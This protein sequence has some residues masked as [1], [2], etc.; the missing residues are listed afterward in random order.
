MIA[1]TQQPLGPV[2]TQPPAAT[3]PVLNELERSA[4]LRAINSGYRIAPERDG[5]RHPLQTLQFFGIRP[6]D[7][8]VE[9]WP[10]QGWYTSILAP[11]LKSGNGRLVAA[12]FDFQTSTSSAVRQLVDD[13]SRRF[14]RDPDRFG[15]VEVVPFGPRSGPLGTP[16]SADAVVTFRNVHNW[17]AQGWGEKAFA[18]MYAVLKP[19]GILGVVDHRAAP[20]EPQDPLAS[21]GYMREDFVIELAEE[22]GFEFIGRSEI[23]ANPRDTRDHPFGVWTLPPVLRTAPLG[24]PDDRSFDST[25][26]R[27]IGESDR[28]T[29]RFKK[30]EILPPATPPMPEPTPKDASGTG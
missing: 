16:N 28:M 12:H 6:T 19:G 18:D 17:V 11:Y 21:S 22:A 5:A 13:F 25:P 23:N 26:Y 14:A 15:Q 1:I 2:G 30:P 29:L 27:L 3:V 10:G 8:V 20:D 9:I 24:M 7:T 4:L